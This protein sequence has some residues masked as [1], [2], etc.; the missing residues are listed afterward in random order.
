MRKIFKLSKNDK[1]S[2][3]NKVNSVLTTSNDL[4]PYLSTMIP[5]RREPVNTPTGKSDTK[6]DEPTASRE[7]FAV[8]E[9]KTEPTT[10]NAIPKNHAYTGRQVY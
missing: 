10:M 3:P 9:G 4:Y 5:N 1:P 7:Y 6:E 8:R 2:I